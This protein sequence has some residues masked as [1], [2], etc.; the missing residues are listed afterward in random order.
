MNINIK[1]INLQVRIFQTKKIELDTFIRYWAMIVKKL[2]LCHVA[3]FGMAFYVYAYYFI[4]K[5]DF[6]LTF[7]LMK[8]FFQFFYLK[9]RWDPNLL[10]LWSNKHKHKKP[11]Q[12][13]QPVIE[14]PFN[15]YSSVTNK[16]IEFKFFLHERSQLVDY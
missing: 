2:A 14:N 9:E 13:C 8:E 3:R 6:D 15:N 1:F 10:Q 5:K 7:F 4:T 12:I 16:D 11:C